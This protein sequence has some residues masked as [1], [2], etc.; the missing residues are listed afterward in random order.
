M[1]HLGKA[2]PALPAVS[3]YILESCSP[4]F[5][6]I[7]AGA[8]PPWLPWFLGCTCLVSPWHWL[9]QLGKNF[10]MEKCFIVRVLNVVPASST[11]LLQRQV[12]QTSSSPK[13]YLGDTEEILY[14]KPLSNEIIGSCRATV[15]KYISKMPVSIWHNLFFSLLQ[16]NS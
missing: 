4:H 7:L 8:C 13:R 10:C 2:K 14:S 15:H 3:L 11:G 6:P 16:L 5:L 9:Q 12:I 1:A